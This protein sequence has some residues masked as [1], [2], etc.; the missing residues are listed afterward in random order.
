M[1]IKPEVISR[2]KKETYLLKLSEDDFRDKVVRPLFL[3]LKLKDGRDFCGPTEKGKDVIFIQETA[4]NVDEIIAIQT[5]KGSLNLSKKQN[6]NVVEAITQLRTALETK[7]FF[8]LTKEKKLP[9]KVFLCTSGKIN[10]ASRIHIA[11]EIKDTRLLFMDSDDIIPLIDQHIP[12]LWL[13]IDAELMPYLRNIK[14]SIENN[15]NLFS[16]SDILT[17]SAL[18]DSATDDMFIPL[19]LHRTVLKLKKQSGRM[20]HVPKFEEI[21]IIGLLS[22]KENLFLIQGDAGTGKSTALRRIMYVLAKKGIGGN[23]KFVIPV[24]L[25][26]NNDKLRDD[27]HSL[28]E[29]S[30]EETKRITNS[31]NPSISNDNINNGD[32]I[33]LIDALDELPCDEHREIVMNKVLNFSNNYSN[34]KIIITSRKISFLNKNETMKKLLSY[35]ISPINFTDIDRI[36]KRFEK[37]QALTKEGAKEIMRRLQ[38]IH[39]MELNPLLVTIFAATSDYNRKDIPANITELFKKFTEMMLG[40]WDEAKR[41]E[42]QYHA[43]LKDFLICKIAFEMHRRKHTAIL[44]KEFRDFIEKELISRGYKGNVDQLTDEILNR[45]N[46]FRFQEDKIEFRHFL[47][48]EFFAGRGIPSKDYLKSIV[49]DLW[50]QRAIV[51]YFGQNPEESAGL[52]EIMEYSDI[53]TGKD[54]FTASLTIGLALQAAY[55]VKIDVKSK[56]IGKVIRGISIC[57]DDVIIKI[58]NYNHPLMNFIA[59]YLIGRDSVACNFLAEQAKDIVS[60]FNDLNPSQEEYEIFMFWLIIGLIES[61]ALDVAEKYVKLF[62]PTNTRFLLA[63]HLGC[64]LTQNLRVT[65]KEAKKNAESI[66]R[67]LEERI[68]KLREEFLEEYKSELLEL[69][70]GEIVAIENSQVK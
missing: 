1:E 38:Q 42:H 28:V 18:S 60:N 9:A 15:S 21:P 29:I 31:N 39:G 3:R 52:L 11:T 50:W 26:A 33:I 65:S 35:S 67:R 62:K 36:L 64:F 69:K 17:G 48:Q 10:E 19:K 25:R 59:Y 53:S 47:L 46:L 49:Y 45:S 61:G 54:I 5:K 16:N 30:M 7:I 4:W 37:K 22:R 2:F 13:G 14:S 55:L 8:I 57:K 6:A 24:L 70:M 63:I 58:G 12:E 44:I 40:R 68:K 27:R 20:M 23:K 66:M 51:F 32:V 43:P 56:L 34:C 41:L